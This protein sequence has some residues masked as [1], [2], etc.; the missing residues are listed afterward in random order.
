MRRISESSTKP[1]FVSP[2]HQGD[3]PCHWAVYVCS[4]AGGEASLV[5]PLGRPAYTFWPV[6]W[7]CWYRC[8]QAPG[9]QETSGCDPLQNPVRFS[10]ASIQ[11]GESHSGGPREGSGN[12]TR[13]I[14]YLE[15]G[16]HR[17]G[18]SSQKRVRV[19]HPVL[20]GSQK[21]WRVVS[22]FRSASVKLLSQQTEVQDAHNLVLSQISSKNWFVTIDLKYAYFISPSFPL[23]EI[24]WGLLSGAK[25]TNIGFFLSA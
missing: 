2:R 21:G 19:L 17:G 22:L 1:R 4:G 10:S 12:G 8:W 23:T 11:R 20:H 16:G 15:E 14:Y 3:R 7:H 24:Y 13:S 18:P 6:R 5:L 9:G 25:L